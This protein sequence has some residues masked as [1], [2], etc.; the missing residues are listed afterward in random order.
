[1]APIQPLAWELPYDVG[2]APKTPKNKQTNKKQPRTKYYLAHTR[3]ARTKED[4]YIA[5][6]NQNPLWK[7]S[8]SL[9]RC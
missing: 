8:G 1:M 6:E 5:G 2:V 4:G 9:L 3:M 7:Q